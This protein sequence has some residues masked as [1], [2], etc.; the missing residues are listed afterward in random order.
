MSGTGT[1]IIQCPCCGE[2]LEIDRKSG[3]ILRRWAKTDA[4]ESRDVFQARLDSIE[5]DKA[6]L[7]AAFAEAGRKM[8]EREEELSSVFDE[9]KEKVRKSGDFS[10]PLNPFDLD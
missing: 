9:Q 8:R 10:R 2:Q 5:Q 1:I 6:R 7:D 3:K 4:G